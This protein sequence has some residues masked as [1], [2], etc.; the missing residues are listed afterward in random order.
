M[1]EPVKLQNIYDDIVYNELV[2]ASC[3]LEQIR[4]AAVSAN[5]YINNAEPPTKKIPLP[6]SFPICLTL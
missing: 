4:S 5:Y 1:S 6:V 3:I 2:D